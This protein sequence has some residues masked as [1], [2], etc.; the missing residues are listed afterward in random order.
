MKHRR[1]D[2][3]HSYEL[4]SVPQKDGY[5]FVMGGTI[6]EV[7]EARDMHGACDYCCFRK[8]HYCPYTDCINLEAQKRY[9]YIIVSNYNPNMED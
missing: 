1:L 3:Y 6:Y 4:H 5:R 2:E 7:V 9:Y 8:T